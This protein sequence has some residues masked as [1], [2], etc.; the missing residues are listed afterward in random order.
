MYTKIGLQMFTVRDAMN[1][2]AGIRETFR[3]IREIG[4]E[5]IQTA[6]CQIPYEA[7]GRLA[8]EEGLT[9]VGTHDPWPRMQEDLEGAIKDHKILGTTNMGIGG[10]KPSDDLIASTEEFIEKANK[11]GDII[12]DH[13]MKFTYHNHSHEFTKLENGKTIMDM[14]VEGLNPQTTSFVLDTYWVQHGGANPI[15]WI[16]KLVGRI[17]IL[18]LKDMGIGL[19]RKQF[20]TEVG[21]GNINFVPIL[22]AAENTGIKH[23]CVEQDTCNGKDPFECIKSS[24]DYLKSII[25]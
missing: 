22:K 3:R 2:E 10:F 12:K 19:D 16:E 18:H 8:K 9:I 6:G 24:Y 13:G 20:I 21:N 25:K 23:I 4:Y 11:I 15:E 7:Y 1:D 14:L 5:E 17:D